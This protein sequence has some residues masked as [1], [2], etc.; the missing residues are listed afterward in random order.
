[1]ESLKGK[2]RGEDLY[3]RVSAVIEKMK[4]PWSKLANITTG[5]SPNLMG[6]NVGLLK[7]IQDKE[8]ENPDQDVIFPSLH[9]S[10]GISVQ[11]CIAA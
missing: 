7:R 10:S 4:L 5:G 1:M 11:V 9:H 6:K 2:M 3:D 8:K